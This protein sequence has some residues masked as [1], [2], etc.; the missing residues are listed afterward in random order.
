MR[1]AELIAPHRFRLLDGTIPDPP[2]GEIQVRVSSVGICGSDLHNFSEGA[3]GDMPSQFPMVLGHE[4]AGTI[5]KTGPGVTGWSTGDRAALE[6]AVYCYHC[7][8][9]MSGRHNV[10]ANLRFLSQPGDP[11]FLRDYVNVPACNVLPMP[12][13]LSLDEGTLFEPLAVALHS[14]EFAQPRTG[15]SAVVFGAGPIGLLTIAALRLSGIA[16]IFA[17]D[18]LAHRLELARAMGASAGIQPRDVDPVKQILADTGGRGV[19]FAIDCATKG[20]SINQCL[21]VTRNFGRVVLTGIPS[22]VRVPLEFH[23]MRRKELALYNVRRSNHESALAL[24]V[25]S[26]H[27]GLFAPL[28]TH[29]KPLE[30]VEAAFSL[31]EQYQDG[32]GKLLISVD[33]KV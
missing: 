19:D 20:E 22:E 32:V 13:N 16:R 18:P 9:C 24:R 28:I 25:L 29:R 7:E 6:P 30:Q 15:E 11:G 26:E 4:P 12:A 31:L 10:C 14:M 33:A 8:F 3:V 17:V 2:P 5:V 27:S 23:V 1:V 21:H